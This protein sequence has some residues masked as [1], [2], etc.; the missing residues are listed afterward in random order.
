MKKNKV[1]VA[2][3]SAFLSL[4]FLTNIFAQKSADRCEVYSKETGAEFEEQERVV[5]CPD[6]VTY[7]HN[8][9]KFSVILP[10]HWNKIYHSKRK[11]ED[12]GKFVSIGFIPKEDLSP[13]SNVIMFHIIIQKSKGANLHKQ[14][15]DNI[16]L[17]KKK[18]VGFNLESENKDIKIANKSAA[19]LIFS[20]NSAAK[21]ARYIICVKDFVYELNFACDSIDTYNKHSPDF[22]N[23]LKNITI[24]TGVKS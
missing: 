16:N 23:I 2:L 7:I 11:P 10:A 22:D 19:K 20:S 5:T 8:L 24:D 13:N 17:S 18:I 12:Y 9:Y 3:I 6:S 14:V 1:R 21:T 15:E 4:I